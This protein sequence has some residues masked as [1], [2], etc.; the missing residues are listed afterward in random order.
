M[1]IKLYRT[2]VTTRAISDIIERMYGYRYSLVTISNISKTTQ[3]NVGAFHERSLETNYS[4]LSLD[5]TYLPLRRGT[6]SKECIH[7]VLG[8]T[9]EGQKVVLGYENAQNENNA[10]WSTLLEKLQNQGIQQVSLVVTDGFKG[11]GQMIS[12]A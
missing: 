9:P 2:G 8:M 10:S 3:E 11:F 5:G 4:V 7:I 12:Q 6:V 1:V